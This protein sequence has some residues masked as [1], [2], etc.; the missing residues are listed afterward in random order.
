M[1]SKNGVYSLLELLELP[2]L[3]LDSDELEAGFDSLPSPSLVL[4]FEER[5]APEGERWSVA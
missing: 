3:L 4:L 5:P 1:S 2:E